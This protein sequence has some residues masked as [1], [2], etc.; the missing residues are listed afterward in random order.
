MTYR[1]LL[2]IPVT[3]LATLALASPVWAGDDEGEIPDPTP[4][5]TV[6]PV[7]TPEPTATPA[8]TVAPPP[9]VAPA[10]PP[11][12]PAPTV[13]P[14]PPPVPTAAPHRAKKKV[15]HEQA[16]AAPRHVKA[17][18]KAKAQTPHRTV[19]TVAPRPVVRAAFVPTAVAA[20]VTT[21][22]GG[23]QAGAGGMADRPGGP[24]LFPLAVGGLLV[25]LF[26]GTT[27][28]AALRR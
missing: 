12:V 20:A 1:S 18:A 3:L 15:R 17:K 24:P 13:A 21:P 9:P 27:I 19:T 4:T 10:P 6:E 28:R 25:L 8:P 5:P 22:S 7:I 14:P 26:G 11:V 16:K 23:V 2:T